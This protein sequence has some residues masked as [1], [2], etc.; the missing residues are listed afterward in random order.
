MLLV[1]D[2]MMSPIVTISENTPLGEAV[3]LMHDLCISGLPVVDAEG[4]L[5]GLVTE[6]DV[7]QAMMPR[8]T[9][10]LQSDPSA[11][12]TEAMRQRFCEIAHEPVSQFMA[13]NIATISD[14]ESIL[15]AAGVVLIRK[16][17]RV[18][19][20]REGKPVGIVS[21]VDILKAMLQCSLNDVEQAQAA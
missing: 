11:V 19:V 16:C 3:A 17:K 7:I 20:V 8:T 15:E 21:R 12:R 5:V 14:H 13:K 10:F 2:V 6:Y 4:S 18:P 9:D 1:K